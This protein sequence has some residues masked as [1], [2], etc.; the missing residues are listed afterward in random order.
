[1]G[2]ALMEVAVWIIAIILIARYFEVVVGLAIMA[3]IAAFWLAVGAAIIGG[4]IWL[5]QAS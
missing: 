4:L 1:M 3:L 2:G 5:G